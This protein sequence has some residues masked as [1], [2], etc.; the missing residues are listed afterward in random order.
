MRDIMVHN[1]VALILIIFSIKCIDAQTLSGNVGQSELRTGNYAEAIKLLTEHLSKSPSDEIAEENLLRAYLET[2]QYKEAETS[3]QKFLSSNPNAVGIRNKLGEVYNTTGRYMEAIKEFERAAN[4]TSS[5]LRLESDLYRAEVLKR[6]GQRDQAL[7]IF[8]SI[9]IFYRSND[10]ATAKE[11]TIAAKALVHLERFKD[12]SELFIEAT[13]VDGAYIDAPLSSGELFTEKYNYDEA[14]EFFREALAINPNSA[15]AHLGIAKNKRLEGGE[16]MEKS[17]ARALEINPN[18]VEARVLR[19]TVALESQDF[20][21]AKAEIEKAF[22]IN[23]QSLEAKSLKAAMLFLQDQ[24]YEAEIKSILAIN[25]QYG[26]VFDTLSHFA[27]ITRRYKQAA[28]FAK[29]GVD[30][31]PRLWNAHLSLGT[32]LLRLGQ[33]KEGRASIETAFEGDPFN[34]WAKNTLDLL[35]TMSD[36]KDTVHRSFIIKAAAQESAAL[37]TYVAD[38]LEEAE[39]KLNTKYKFKPEGPILVELYPSHEDFAVRT[40]GLPGLGALGVCFGQVVALDSP[41]ARPIGEFNWGSTLW[42]EYT[43]VLTLQMTD[44]R[45]PRWFSEGLSVYEERRGRPGWGDDWNLMVLKALDEKRWFKIGN[46]EAGFQ[47]PRTPYDV[48]LAYF[49]ASQICEFIVD[50]Y[51]F[52]AILQMLELYKNRFK[53]PEVL[54]KTLKL[55]EAEFDNSFNQYIESKAR[56]YLQAIKAGASVSNLML[57]SKEEI[58]EMLRSYPNDYA[59]N[60]RLGELYQRQE[61]TINKAIE[62]LRRSIELF[63]YQTG[64]MN[65]YEQLA[66]LYEKNGNIGAAAETWDA[67]VRQD[68]TNLNALNQLIRLRL[69]QGDKLQATEALQMSFY[70]TPFNYER[71]AECG[72]LYI[73]LNQHAKAMREFQVALSLEPPNV[74]EAN[75]NV[76]RA[77]HGLGKTLD[78]KRAVLRALELAPSYEEAQD[79][80]LEIVGQ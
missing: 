53:T 79:L 52:N 76:A 63:P 67:L 48:P 4:S 10:A 74:A 65:A 41:S 2:G 22:K 20:D 55:S 16:E 68:E 32:A 50:K 34:V 72:K 46:I 44:Y 13:S 59:L 28:L 31:D 29:R 47:H 21:E 49:Q 30:V 57:L 12:A 77:F 66:Q 43:H 9:V 60:L 38:L 24:D 26:M 37:T 40:L 75:Y 5:I 78:A 14:A 73:S 7:K 71:H 27:T 51:G 64:Q 3:A 6:I 70:I 45:I 8:E 25:P 39:T 80:L 62:H 18:F 69:L 17:L 54:Q 56:P 61:D 36:Y 33:I 42:H 11:L 19:A 15:R 58:E 1:V 23:P 35:D